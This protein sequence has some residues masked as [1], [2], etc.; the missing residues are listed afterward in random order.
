[1]SD[2]KPH[3][4]TV[5]KSVIRSIVKSF[6]V[7][8]IGKV[9]LSSSSGLPAYRVLETSESL[10]MTC[11]DLAAA[12]RQESPTFLHSFV[13]WLLDRDLILYSHTFLKD[14]MR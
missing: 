3:K 12:A 5:V 10:S 2:Y 6:N 7:A 9:N 11:I 13:N 4:M 8:P 1:M 14:G